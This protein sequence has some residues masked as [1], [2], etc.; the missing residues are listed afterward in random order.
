M[1]IRTDNPTAEVA[2]YSADGT[3]LA[4]KIWQGHRQLAETLHAT[5]RDLLKEQGK[6]WAD[7]TGVVA[8]KG[9]GSFTGLRIGLAAANALAY[10]VSCP[11]IGTKGDG[12][13]QQ[14]VQLLVEGHGE[15]AVMPEYDAPVFITKQRK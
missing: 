5:I 6:D 1:T 8:F 7:I 11:I 3:R 14:G 12:W 4:E 15:H 9:P 13:E 2:L 10:G